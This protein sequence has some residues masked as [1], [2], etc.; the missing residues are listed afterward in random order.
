M[1]MFTEFAVKRQKL[2]DAEAGEQERNGKSG[3]VKCREEQTTAP[4]AACRCQADDAAKYWTNAGRPTGGESNT[5]S[6]RTQN[7]TR[8]FAGEET[9]VFIKRRNFQQTDQLQSKQNDDDAADNAYPNVIDDCC[10]HQSR[11]GTEREKNYGQSGIE[12]QRIKNDC[13][14]RVAAGIAF[15]QAINT[16]SRHQGNIAGHQRQH[17]WR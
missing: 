10:A 13:A 5:Q 14:T 2:I 11:G 3:R 4:T 6:K 12:C 7:S 16:D 8:F 1:K 15:F 17:A 9:G